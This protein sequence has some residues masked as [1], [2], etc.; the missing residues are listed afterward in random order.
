M[1]DDLVAETHPR[2]HE[3][4]VHLGEG[5]DHL[6][7]KIIKIILSVILYHDCL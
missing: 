6:W 1:V 4:E 5:E 7:N 2:V 3:D